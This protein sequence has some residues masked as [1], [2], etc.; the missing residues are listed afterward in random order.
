MCCWGAGFDGE[1]FSTRRLH[2]TKERCEPPAST[3][4]AVLQVAPLASAEGAMSLSPSKKHLSALR[5]VISP[6][7]L[8][9]DK[10]HWGAALQLGL[11]CG[12]EELHF[13]VMDGHFVPALSFGPSVVGSLRQA[14]RDAFFDVHFMVE[15]PERFVEPLAQC[16]AGS[17]PGLLGFTFHVEATQPRNAT[18]STIELIRN[19]GMRVGLAL[20]PDTAV[21]EVLPF[22]HLVDLVLVMTVRPGLGGQ[23]FM[24]QTLSKVERV[25]KQYPHMNIQVDGGIKAGST[26]QQ[27][28]KAGA[29]FI[30]SG[31]GVYMAKD[32]KAAVDEMRLA[33][34]ENL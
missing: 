14:F 5:A 31:S 20:S 16:A 3:P 33:V 25:R 12:A 9:C 6:S 24:P 17:K 11:D 18:E 34:K 22:C 29:N 4:R 8:D 27:A 30:V 10:A 15:F 7:I 1:H 2:T 19:A 23:A 21:E 13:D 32:P 28:A 26:V